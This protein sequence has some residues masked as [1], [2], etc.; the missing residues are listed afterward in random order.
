MVTDKRAGPQWLAGSDPPGPGY[1][2]R[3]SR[4]KEDRKPVRRRARERLI[5][6]RTPWTG[7]DKGRQRAAAANGA[8]A[9][10]R[11]GKIS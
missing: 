1:F 4:A 10:E 8:A 3:V 11:R 5:L 9:A 6:V 2:I 7:A